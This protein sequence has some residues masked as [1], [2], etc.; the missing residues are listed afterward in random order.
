MK[1]TASPSKRRPDNTTLFFVVLAITSALALW[2]RDGT[3]NLLNAFGHA[4][5]L[6]LGIAP[7]V[8]AALL[9]G[10]YA[11]ALLP[12]DTIARWLR[13]TSGTGV[14]LIAIFAGTLTPAGPFA[15]FPLVLAL[16]RAGVPFD[17]CVVYLSAWGTLGI[18]RIVI[19]ELPFLGHD[20][21]VL[22]VLSSLPVPIVAGLVARLFFR[23][24]P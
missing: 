12:R 17:V 23:N 20:F 1:S 16:R 15:A 14:Y 24:T 9:V 6:L 8:V 2:W 19:W 13:E 7:I 22:R 3:E 4:G 5:M 18:H 21:V 11:Q 10:G